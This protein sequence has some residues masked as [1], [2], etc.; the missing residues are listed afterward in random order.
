LN[1]LFSCLLGS[2]SACF[3]NFFVPPVFVLQTF[4]YAGLRVYWQD[5][6]GIFFLTVGGM[7]AGLNDVQAISGK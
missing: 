6:H 1:H 5:V 7:N 2:I 3:D 4:P